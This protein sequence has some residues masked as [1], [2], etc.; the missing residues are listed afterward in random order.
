VHDRA[1]R[2]LRRRGYLDERAAEDRSNEAAEPSALDGCTQLALAGGALL[3]R[4]DTP[5][6]TT[7]ADLEGHGEIALHLSWAE[8]LHAAGRVEAAHAALAETISRLKKRLDDIPEP[9]ARERYLTNVPA[10]ARVLALTKVWLGDA[11]VRALGP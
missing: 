7:D 9:A 5:S 10:N 8:A 6:D 3:A 2:W 11:A 1:V 4:P